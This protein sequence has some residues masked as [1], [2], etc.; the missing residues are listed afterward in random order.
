[1]RSSHLFVHLAAYIAG[2]VAAP[3]RS[4][5][6]NIGTHRIRDIGGQ[7][8]SMYHPEGVYKTFGIGV[9]APAKKR[10]VS[11]A[12][13]NALS[14]LMQELGVSGDALEIRTSANTDMGERIWAHQMIVSIIGSTYCQNKLI[15]I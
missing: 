1:M 3:P 2:C 7:S 15:H 9:E 6:F 11:S 4:N 5:G 13:D 14:F 12:E 8:V 10:G